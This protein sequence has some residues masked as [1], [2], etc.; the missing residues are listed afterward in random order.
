LIA[1]NTKEYLIL[2]DLLE[3]NEKPEIELVERRL[4]GAR[5][6]GVAH[7]YATTFRIIVIRRYIFDLRR[8]LKIIKYA[9]ITET[10]VERGMVYCK[11]HFALQGHQEEYDNRVKWIVGLKYDEVVALT[12]FVNKDSRKS[13]T[14]N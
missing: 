1:E 8:S 12:K 13:T 6:F 5:W 7:V 9:D 3:D 10:N 4:G 11:V 14:K 2:R